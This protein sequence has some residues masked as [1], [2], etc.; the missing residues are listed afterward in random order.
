MNSPFSGTA[1]NVTDCCEELTVYDEYGCTIPL[2]DTNINSGATGL[3]PGLNVAVVP[4]DVVS[5]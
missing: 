1:S 4:F 5:K 2:I 3:K